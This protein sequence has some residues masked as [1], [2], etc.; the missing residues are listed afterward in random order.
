MLSVILYGR[1]DTHGNNYHKRLAIS[2]NCIA[3]MLSLAGDEIFFVDYNSPEAGPTVIESV[4]DTLTDKAKSV[5]RVLRVRSSV[6]RGRKSRLPLMEPLAR[7]I[8]IR[9]MNPK[10]RWVLSTNPDMIFVPRG[11]GKTLSE[12]AAALPDG[13]YGLPRFELPE[14]FWDLHLNRLK[15]Q[16]NIDFLRREGEL[17]RLNTIVRREGFLLFDNPGD[18]Q[19]MLREDIV[20]IQG[21]HEEMTAG[22][23][24]DSNLCKRMSLIQKFFSLEEQLWGYHCN[25]ALKP[26][27]LS[28]KYLSENDWGTFVEKVETPFVPAQEKNWGLPEE[29][30]EEISLKSPIPSHAEALKHVLAG[31]KSERHEFMLGNFFAHSLHYS[32]ARIFPYLMDQ[33]LHLA[34][35]ESIS[36]IGKNQEI[37]DLIDRYFKFRKINK[38]TSIITNYSE[39]HKRYQSG[40]L[41]VFDFGNPK[42]IIKLFFILCRLSRKEGKETKVIGINAFAAGLNSLFARHFVLTN[43]GYIPGVTAGHVSRDKAPFS[44]KNRRQWRLLFAHLTAR[45][46]YDYKDKV[47]SFSQK[48]GFLKNT[49]KV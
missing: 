14:N 8:A 48:V 12:I 30:I 24:V 23:H 11:T 39:L 15:P 18:F 13:F 10:N 2:I 29:N 32:P 6:H 38:K 40:D 49:S 35:A 42:Q 17:L 3:E 27:V 47:R 7:N 44:L 22:W 33:L 43:G 46:F 41:F 37:Y 25:H 9:R 1:N 28:S 26:S 36:Y 21:F 5:L 4:Q 31:K 45:H 16:D 20:R 19:L 34:D